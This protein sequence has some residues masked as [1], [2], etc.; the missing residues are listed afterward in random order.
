METGQRSIFQVQDNHLTSQI[1]NSPA[2]NDSAN[3]LAFDLNQE[4]NVNSNDII[5]LDSNLNL[6]TQNA[7]LNSE[8]DDSQPDLPLVSYKQ[9]IKNW[10]SNAAEF[11]RQAHIAF[12][13]NDIDLMSSFLHKFLDNSTNAN[14][15]NAINILKW[16]FGTCCI[17]FYLM[18]LDI[19]NLT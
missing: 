2:I 10:C 3:N 12:N 9:A 5:N 16:L 17:I 13:N 1:H 18:Y 15:T 4:E 11:I 14:V 7:T 19:M 6:E 8:S